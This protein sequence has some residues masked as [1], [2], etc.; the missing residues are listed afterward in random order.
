MLGP[1]PTPQQPILQSEA[2][3]RGKLPLAKS[4]S[5]RGSPEPPESPRP[6]PLTRDEAEDP[7]PS[8]P[9]LPATRCDLPLGIGAFPEDPAPLPREPTKGIWGPPESRGL[10]RKSRER[11]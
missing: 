6:R 4:S 11:V 2:L 3:R 7:L 8:S 5:I 1:T 9:G 10:S